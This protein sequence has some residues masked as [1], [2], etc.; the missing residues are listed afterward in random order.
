MML[1]LGIVDKPPRKRTTM[2]VYSADF[3]LPDSRLQGAQALGTLLMLL[4]TAKRIA[5]LAAIELITSG[6]PSSINWH[7]Q[8]GLSYFQLDLRHLKSLCYERLPIP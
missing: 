2:N 3:E 7:G 4:A 6:K 5:S 1:E 8:Q